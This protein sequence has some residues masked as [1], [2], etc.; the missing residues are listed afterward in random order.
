MG[1]RVLGFRVEGRG[2][3]GPYLR[4]QGACGRYTKRGD[5]CGV[6][7]RALGLGR[8]NLQFADLLS[9]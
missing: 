4:G 9:P 5:K 7:C 8:M 1:F 2:F 3:V 6:A